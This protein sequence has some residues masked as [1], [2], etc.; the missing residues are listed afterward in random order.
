MA[1]LYTTLR[2]SDACLQRAVQRSKGREC[3]TVTRSKRLN[4]PGT[5]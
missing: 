3:T 2:R 4:T 1:Q 5:P